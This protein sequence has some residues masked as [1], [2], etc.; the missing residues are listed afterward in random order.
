MSCGGLLWAPKLPKFARQSRVSWKDPRNE[1][2][3]EKF[4]YAQVSLS[5]REG[6]KGLCDGGA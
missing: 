2:V 6:L 4:T 5:S 3:A 1:A